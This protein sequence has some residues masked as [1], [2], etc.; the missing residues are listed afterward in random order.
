MKNNQLDE[1]KNSLLCEPLNTV[2]NRH[3]SSNI[4]SLRKYFTLSYWRSWLSNL[5]NGESCTEI[6]EHLLYKSEISTSALICTQLQIPDT[7]RSQYEPSLNHKIGF[8]V[9][10][11]ITQHALFLMGIDSS[12]GEYVS[13]ETI[14][15]FRKYFMLK[16]YPDKRKDRLSDYFL[17]F[18]KG[19]EM[20]LEEEYN[21]HEHPES[22]KVRQEKLMLNEVMPKLTTNINYLSDMIIQTKQKEE[23]AFFETKRDIFTILGLDETSEENYYAT[24]Q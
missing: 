19:Y 15:K 24:I 8:F 6:T 22:R 23:I 12:E 14:K 7:W 18:Q 21:P 16:N 1:T 11:A 2:W 10:S 13:T 17:T 5:I 3:V 4:A 20:L 9:R